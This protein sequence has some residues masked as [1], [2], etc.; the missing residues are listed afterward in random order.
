M[1]K[2]KKVVRPKLKYPPGEATC[3]T[4]TKPDGWTTTL[5]RTW[6]GQRSLLARK[7][8]LNEA[9]GNPYSFRDP[10]GSVPTLEPYPARVNGIPA[11][12]IDKGQGFY[13]H[14]VKE[15]EE[16]LARIKARE[17]EDRARQDARLKQLQ[18]EREERERLE[19]EQETK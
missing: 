4:L 18:K 11:S 19:S 16:W 12:A 6:L 14:Q 9:R 10:D 3:G 2:K 5:W 7:L 8:V 17:T 1:A 13:D 15:R